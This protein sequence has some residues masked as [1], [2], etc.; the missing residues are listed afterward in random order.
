MAEWSKPERI[1]FVN[2]PNGWATHSKTY[3]YGS[4]VHLS[5]TD[6]PDGPNKTRATYDMTSED[7]GRTW[8]KPERLTLASDGEWWASAAAGTDMYAVALMLAG[9]QIKY[10]RRDFT[11]SHCDL[12]HH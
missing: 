6:A 11:T 9:D 1:T 12:H 7:G 10:R 5:W 8:E 2:A 4:R 3:T